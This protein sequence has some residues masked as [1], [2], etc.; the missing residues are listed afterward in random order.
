MLTASDNQ[1]LTQVSAGTPGGEVLRRY[2][3]PFLLSDELAAPD[4]PPLRIRL[5]G[6]DLIAFRTSSAAVG[7]ISNACPHRGASLFFARNEEEGLRCVYHGWKFDT[8]GQCVDM[9][10]EPAESNFKAKIRATAY[11]CS[12]RNG[13]VWT[14]MGQCEPPPLPDLEWNLV[15]REQSYVSKRVQRCNWFQALE[16]GIDSTHSNFIHAPLNT[17]A[18]PQAQAG[19]RGPAAYR[20]RAKFLHFEIVPTNYGLIVANRRDAEEGSYYWRMNHFLLPFY[21]MFPPTGARPET[22]ISGHAWVPIDDESTLVFHWSYNPEFPIAK[23]YIETAKHGNNGIDGFHLSLESRLPP[24]SE[25]HG[26][27]RP[28]QNST[29]DYLLDYEAQRT[30]R[31]SGVPGGWNQDAAVQE[32]MGAVTNRAREHL[33]TSDSGIIAARR[34]FL[35]IVEGYCE[36]REDPPAVNDPSAWRIRPVEAVLPREADWLSTMRAKSLAPSPIA[37]KPGTKAATS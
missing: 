19:A 16:G 14:F 33:G 1:L 25:A 13:V 27:W 24:T 17:D 6:E 29:N 8:T 21:T 35:R 31:F 5:L 12:E 26:A 28:R 37:I 9:P 18:N 15:P 32:T 10:S 4:C 36:R 34:Y 22:P 20:S 2:W 11:P 7:L 3:I 23:R 30:V